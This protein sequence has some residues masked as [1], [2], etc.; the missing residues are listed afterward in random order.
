MAFRRPVLSPES[1]GCEKSAPAT[2]RIRDRARFVAVQGASTT[3]AARGLMAVAMDL[4]FV[5]AIFSQ[6]D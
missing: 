1:A 5:A 6:E 3:G 2:R 4:A